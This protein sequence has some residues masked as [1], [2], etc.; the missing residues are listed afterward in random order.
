[1][2]T[3]PMVAAH[4]RSGDVSTGAGGRGLAGRRAEPAPLSVAPMM[5][6]T[7]SHFRYF[8]RRIT[9]RTLLY[10][11]MIHARAVLRG[12]RE[13][14]LAFDPAEA[15]VALQLG[16]D[17]PAELA[18][19][20]AIGAAYGYAEVD[21]NVGCPS[22][23]VRS[24][25]FGA[26]LMATPE[27]VAAGVRAM[28]SAT[29]LPITV[30]HRIGIDLADA[31]EDL[32]RFVAVVAEAGADAFIVH[33][34][35]AWLS[36]LSPKENRSVPPLRYDDVYRLKAAFPHLLV[37]IN[38]GVRSLDDAERHL[39]RVDGVMIGRAAYENPYLLADAD[40]RFY[41]DDAPAPTRAEVVA[42]MVPYARERVR[43][44]V[45]V[46]AI[47][48]HVLGLFR[49][50]PGGKAW[51]RAVT[52]ASQRPGAGADVLLEGLEAV[53]NAAAAAAQFGRSEMASG[54]SRP[55]TA[56]TRAR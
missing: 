22:E 51:R 39:G 25:N 26:C 1:M 17:D 29:G 31:Y 13:R 33:A 6:L 11:E 2:A 44:G 32:E 43:D 56:G 53:E 14:L 8:A 40:A 4:P 16:G 41:G 18:E 49:G 47:T 20:A 52:E 34:R 55:A 10:S 28:R 21:L 12:D 37:E 46:A 9:R 54:L 50:R 30:K 35:K 42:A 15:P 19:A 24:G 38:G 7:D 5:D 45:P 36:G 48:R 23:R 3:E 27:V